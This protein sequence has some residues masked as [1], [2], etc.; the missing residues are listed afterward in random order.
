MKFWCRELLEKPDL[1]R[2][3]GEAGRK[4][5]EEKYNLERF[6]QDWNKLLYKTIG[7]FTC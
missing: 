3:L 1:A 4:T 7:E 6:V 2:K 5:I